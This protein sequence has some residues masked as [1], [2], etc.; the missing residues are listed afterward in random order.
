MKQVKVQDIDKKLL[1]KYIRK[2]GKGITYLSEKIGI[3]TAELKEKMDGKASFLVSE[4][5]V[6]CE[7]LEIPDDDANKIF[8]P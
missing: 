4:I 1:D 8:Y 2:S 7:E 5:L 6:L 3:P